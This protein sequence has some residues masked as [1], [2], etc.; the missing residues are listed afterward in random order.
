[1]KKKLTFP[2]VA[3]VLLLWGAIFYRIFSGLGE[4]GGSVPLA[5]VIRPK[6]PIAERIK[7]DSLLLDYR[8][9][10]LE[11]ADEGPAP[12]GDTLLMAGYE[13]VEEIPYIDWSQ[14]LYFGSVNNSSGRKA[15]ALVNI[16]GKEY[17]LKAGETVDGYTLVGRVGNS[18]AV[19]YQGQVATITMQG[20][21]EI[22]YP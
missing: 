7:D 9:P 22:P 1:M 13:Y 5:A 14:V 21:N 2:L 12:E 4:E 17:M 15:V 6:E 10:F 20:N 11:R 18:I 19:S 3:L 16:N 8:D